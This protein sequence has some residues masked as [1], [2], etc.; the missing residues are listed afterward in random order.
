VLIE[1]LEEMRS[2]DFGSKIWILQYE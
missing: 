2:S 1:I